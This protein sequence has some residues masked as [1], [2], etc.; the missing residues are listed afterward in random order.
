MTDA[1]AIAPFLAQLTALLVAGR[2]LG[3]GNDPG[4]AAR[5]FRAA[6]WRR[7]AGPLSLGDALSYSAAPAFSRL[8]RN[9]DNDRCGV[10]NRHPDAPATDRIGGESQT[11][12]TK[13]QCCRRDIDLR[14]RDP[15]PFC[16]LPWFSAAGSPLPNPARQH[17]TALF[18]GTAL[19]VSSV[20]IVAMVLMEV[21]FIRRDLGQLMLATAI[22]D[23][24]IAWILLAASPAW[25]RMAQP[26]LATSASALR[27]SS[28]F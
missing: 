8:A 27:A 9:Q 23:D 4:R 11:R 22:L 14:D 3:E 5:H 26:A 25:P 1:H 24:T 10:A 16:C 7:P 13:A 12:H 28:F 17:I 18:V 20:K 2:L 19:S 21:G 6:A 15:F